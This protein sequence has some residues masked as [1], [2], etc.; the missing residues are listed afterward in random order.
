[1]WQLFQGTISVIFWISFIVACFIAVSLFTGD[2]S[3]NEDD[4]TYNY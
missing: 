2:G 1:M 3:G 4:N